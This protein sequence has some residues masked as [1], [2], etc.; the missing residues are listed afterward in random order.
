MKVDTLVLSGASTKL[1]LFLGSLRA[2]QEEKLIPTDFQKS[3]PIQHIVCCSS[4]CLVSL[5]LLLGV[6]LDVMEQT[7]LQFNFSDILDIENTDIK[8]LLFEQGVYDHSKC[9]RIIHTVIREKLNKKDITLLELFEITKVRLS[10]KVVN[11]TKSCIEYLSYETYPNLSIVQALLMTTAIPYLFKPITYQSNIYIDGGACGGYPKEIAGDN[12]LGLCVIGPWSSNDKQIY[13]LVPLL[14]IIFSMQS[15][16]NQ[17]PEVKEAR[18][19]LL[20]NSLQL[21]TFEV[22]QE[23]KL[24]MIQQGYQDAKKH[25]MTY[26][27]KKDPIE[28]SE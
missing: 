19:I 11:I 7:L 8:Q 5:L 25:I 17:D 9:G 16:S 24:S 10:I 2:L 1:P 27:I 15:I 26:G 21:T 18:T 28:T 23:T 22:N 13:E 4:G 6:S 3:N 14:Q 20:Y 12:Y